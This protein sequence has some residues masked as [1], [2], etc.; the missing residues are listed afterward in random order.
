MAQQEQLSSSELKYITNTD[1]EKTSVILSLADYQ[2][3]LEDL[4]DLAVI[5]ESKYEVTIPW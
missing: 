1:G 5:T 4:Q 2:G 3:L